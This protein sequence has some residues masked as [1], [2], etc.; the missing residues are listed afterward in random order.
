M[1]SSY[2][3]RLLKQEDQ[4]TIAALTKAAENGQMSWGDAHSQAENI[5][6]KNGYSGGTDG[7][8]YYQ[9]NW[10]SSAGRS[11]EDTLAK[12]KNMTYS[13]WMDSD[14]YRAL[15]AQ[16][17]KQGK[18]AMEDTLAQLSARTGGLASSYAGSAAQ[19]Q[20]ATTLDR[21]NSA[22]R[23]MYESDR[24]NL[25]D[26][27]SAEANEDERAYERLRDSIS[28]E[29]YAQ[30]LALTKQQYADQQAQYAAEQE[31]TSAQ[32]AQSRVAAYLAAGGSVSGLDSDLV[33][34][35]GYTAS[36]LKAFENYYKMQ[37]LAAQTQSSGG[38]E[39]EESPDFKDEGLLERLAGMSEAQAKAYL[40]QNGIGP[41]DAEY[42]ELLALRA[43]Y[44]ASSGAGASA[45]SG[46]NPG[47]GSLD[48]GSSVY[49]TSLDASAAILGTATQ[50]KKNGANNAEIEAYLNKFSE[51]QLSNE[52]LSY[53]AEKL[54]LL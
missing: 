18:L 8:G 6:L 40:I 20:Y 43:E 12:L 46:F 2:D 13:D 14:E 41:E 53:I 15:Q 29:N 54:D 45:A 38:S 1:R 25:A 35:S 7:S 4:D 5:R 32:D 16:Y 10:K 28:D 36:E 51:D 50:M 27:Y 47:V 3:R 26:I 34:K 21:L 17:Q 30:E 9:N 19:Q 37:Q 22:A 39:S 24:S 31:R 44:A 42:E 49:Q 33:E 11:S 23:S 48:I 52:A